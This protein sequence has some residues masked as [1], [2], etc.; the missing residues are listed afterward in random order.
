MPIIPVLTDHKGWNQMETIKLSELLTSSHVFS[1]PMADTR[2]IIRDKIEFFRVLS[3][4]TENSISDVVKFTKGLNGFTNI[5]AADQYTLIKHGCFELLALRYLVYYD[6]R[7]DCF[8]FPYI[9]RITELSVASDVYNYPLAEHIIEIRDETE[10]FRIIKAKSEHFIRDTIKFT[11]SLLSFANTC[12][13]D[14]YVLFKSGVFE[15]IYMQYLDNYD[16][17]RELFH[18]HLDNE[19][20]MLITLQS[21]KETDFNYY[22]SFK[23]F[24]DAMIPELHSDPVIMNLNLTI[25]PVY[26]ELTDYKGF[27]EMES[28]RIGELMAAVIVFNYPLTENVVKIHDKS[29]FYCISKTMTDNHIRDTTVFA[30]GLVSFAN[31]CT[32]D[33]ILLLKLKQQ[34]YIYLLQRYLLL[35][36]RSESESQIKLQ[37]L[38]LLLNDLNETMKVHKSVAVEEIKDYIQYCG[39]LLKE[40]Y[41]LSDTREQ[42]D[43]DK[44]DVC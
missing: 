11:K 4:Y 5:S 9:Q 7:N 29:E 24:L 40:V 19:H 36:Y 22:N 31:T 30:T 35:K 43:L 27:H 26:K 39:P 44:L 15:V 37:K 2:H 13:D 25:I 38:M 41:D 12:P 1:Y 21:Y 42:L 34:L 16:K 17:D 10:L 28:R 8:N 3:Q 33:Q 18:I 23:R 14:Q 20:S 32:D 6:H